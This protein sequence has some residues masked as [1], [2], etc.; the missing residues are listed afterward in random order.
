MGVDYL[1]YG[2]GLRLP[3]TLSEGAACPRERTGAGGREGESVDLSSS[4]CVCVRGVPPSSSS[5]LLLHPPPP[6]QREMEEE[7]DREGG[8]VD[9]D[10]VCDRSQKPGGGRGGGGGSD[11]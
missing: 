6:S 8:V 1:E 5:I 4:L 11:G 3:C 10:V 7:E 2:E 9:A